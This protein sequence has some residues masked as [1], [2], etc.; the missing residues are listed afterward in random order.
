M[1]RDVA[2]R[3]GFGANEYLPHSPIMRSHT[4]KRRNCIPAGI[5]SNIRCWNT[6]SA[7]G[8]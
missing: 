8:H 5:Y 6:V 2:A 1:P 7:A 4:D 3:D